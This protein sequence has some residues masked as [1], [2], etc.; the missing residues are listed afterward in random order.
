MEAAVTKKDHSL[1][2]FRITRNIT[3]RSSGDWVSKFQAPAGLGSGENPSSWLTSVSPWAC[4]SPGGPD[5]FCLPDLHRREAQG[6]ESRG[7]AEEVG[8]GTD[9]LPGE[10]RLRPHSGKAGPLPAVTALF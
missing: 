8:G 2:G 4:L 6:P 5:H 7:G 10:G 1:G 3:S 9:G